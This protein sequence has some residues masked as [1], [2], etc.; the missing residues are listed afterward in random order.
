MADALRH[1]AFEMRNANDNY[2]KVIIFLSLAGGIQIFLMK[3][4]I[5]DVFTFAVSFTITL[6]ATLQRFHDYPKRIQD[7][8]NVQHGIHQ[9]MLLLRGGNGHPPDASA[10]ARFNESVTDFEAT[11]SLAERI[12]FMTI[13]R[14]DGLRE[15]RAHAKWEAELK[16][17]LENP[18]YT[19]QPRQLPSPDAGVRRVLGKKQR[20][21]YQFTQSDPASLDQFRQSSDEMKS[22][23]VITTTENASLTQA[24]WT[25]V[26]ELGID[27]RDVIVCGDDVIMPRNLPRTMSESVEDNLDII[28]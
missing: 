19:A 7:I 28:G 16:Q 6:V 15:V 14:Q 9:T 20:P 25:H 17:V 12:H 13:A 21:I 27:R 24:Q 3:G 2:N 8:T 4:L 23:D 18:T 11:L 26:R 5:G 10:M 1:G 22:G